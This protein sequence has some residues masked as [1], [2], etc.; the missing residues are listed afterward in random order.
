MV[1]IIIDKTNGLKKRY[2]IRTSGYEKEGKE[3]KTIETTIPAE[4]TEREARRNKMSM[5]E[6]I[7]K[8][9]VEWTY[10]SFPGLHLI[11][12]RNKNE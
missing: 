9:D 8:F 3:Y 12:V 11:F 4:V 10:N 5:D 6:F 7:E 1:K 2:K